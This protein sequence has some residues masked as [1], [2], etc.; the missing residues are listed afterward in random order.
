MN[1]PPYRPGARCVVIR[2]PHA[3]TV[4]VL[5]KPIPLKHTRGE[6]AWYIVDKIP[7]LWNYKT[8]RP[9]RWCVGFS[10]RILIP[11]DDPLPGNDV[12]VLEELAA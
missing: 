12:P 6:I 2:G 4:V 3:G 10:Q 8:K 9:C 11:L 1:L 7:V 5:K